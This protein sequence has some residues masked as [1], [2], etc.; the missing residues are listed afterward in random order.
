MAPKFVYKDITHQVK[1]P[2]RYPKVINGYE[3][4]MRDDYKKEIAKL[5][6][7]LTKTMIEFVK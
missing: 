5:V 6:G 2:P 3:N 7:N 4:P 1:D